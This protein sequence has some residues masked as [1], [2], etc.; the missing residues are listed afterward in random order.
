MVTWLRKMGD[1]YD[2]ETL[3]FMCEGAVVRRLSCNCSGHKHQTVAAG[4]VLRLQG[5]PFQERC[6]SAALKKVRT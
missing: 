5:S 1:G 4:R 2:E 6:L 3:G